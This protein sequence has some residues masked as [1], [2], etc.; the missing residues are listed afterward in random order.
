MNPTLEQIKTDESVW[1]EGADFYIPESGIKHAYFIKKIGSDLVYKL[2]DFPD[3]WARHKS[4]I[5]LPAILRPTKAFVPEVGVECEYWLKRDGEDAVFKCQPKY[6]SDKMVVA[7][8]F[9]EGRTIEQALEYHEAGFRPIKS[10]REK[11]VEAVD[12]LI[13]PHHWTSIDI[14]RALYDSGKFKLVEPTK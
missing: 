7:L 5:P 8:C 13:K 10:E 3:N 4:E 12:C 6:V 9:I 11:F 14:A 1:P 2:A